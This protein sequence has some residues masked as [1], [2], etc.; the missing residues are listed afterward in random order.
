MEGTGERGGKGN[1]EPYNLSQVLLSNKS[2]AP[3]ASKQPRKTCPKVCLCTMHRNQR[4]GILQTR[5]NT[6]SLKESSPNSKSNKK[7]SER[8]KGAFC[9]KSVLQEGALQATEG[10][11]R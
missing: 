1:T 9:V 2:I 3:K 7:A 10:P 8:K 5:K 4:K 6:K 11:H